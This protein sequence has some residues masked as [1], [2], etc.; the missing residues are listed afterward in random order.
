[1]KHMTGNTD[2]AKRSKIRLIRIVFLIILSIT[3]IALVLIRLVSSE[4]DNSV[5][6]DQQ[7]DLF[8]YSF[9]ALCILFISITWLVTWI[10]LK[11]LSKDVITHRWPGTHTRLQFTITLINMIPI[12]IAIISYILLGKVILDLP[13]F[14]GLVVI[15]IGYSLNST[16][17]ESTQIADNTNEES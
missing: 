14:T 17:I 12:L 7:L 2:T 6:T 13:L 3:Y 5:F 16:D 8:L 1:M 10:G 9:L 11:I 4:L 15:S